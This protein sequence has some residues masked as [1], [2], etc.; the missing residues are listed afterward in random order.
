[1]TAQRRALQPQPLTHSTASGLIRPGPTGLAHVTCRKS[2]VLC[3]SRQRGRGK[4]QK[5]H[6]L[7]SPKQPLIVTWQLTNLFGQSKQHFRQCSVAPTSPSLLRTV[8]NPSSSSL[9]P[10]GRPCGAPPHST[11]GSDVENAFFPVAPALRAGERTAHA[12]ASAPT[13]LSAC[14]KTRQ[15]TLQCDLPSICQLRRV[16]RIIS[17]IF[18]RSATPHFSGLVKAH[19]CFKPAD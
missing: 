14:A 5:G 11:L 16:P 17:S 15:Q 19:K 7:Q 2:P 18:S 10:A 9:T 3:H 4:D 6:A 12:S 1:M 13:L 8:R